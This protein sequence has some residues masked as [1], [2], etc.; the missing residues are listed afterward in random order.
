MNKHQSSVDDYINTANGNISTLTSEFLICLEDMSA[1]TSAPERKIIETEIDNIENALDKIFKI[2]RTR[3][4]G[5][6]KK[7]IL[8]IIDAN[9]SG[10]NENGINN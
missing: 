7:N 5:Y 8:R 1:I 2:Y 3:I 4:G 6:V 9:F 10:G